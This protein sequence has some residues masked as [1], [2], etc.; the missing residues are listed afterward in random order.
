[1][2]GAGSARLGAGARRGQDPLGLLALA[3]GSGLLSGAGLSGAAAVGALA[4]LST[5]ALSGLAVGMGASEPRFHDDNPARIASS[6]GGVLFMLVGMAYLGL[7]VG[8]LVL[9]LGA[10]S[11]WLSSGFVPRPGRIALYGGL[12]LAAVL[13]SVATHALP[14]RRGARRLESRES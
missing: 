10:F 4:A 5:W 11:F 14:R 6:V 13:L 2:G 7:M 3:V 12:V 1:M 9:P 8:L